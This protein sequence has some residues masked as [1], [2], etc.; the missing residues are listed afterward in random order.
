[1]TNSPLENSYII[2]YNVKNA[3][4]GKS[5]SK[6]PKWPSLRP[7]ECKS[8]FIQQYGKCCWRASSSSQQLFPY[9]SSYSCKNLDSQKSSMF[10][11]DSFGFFHFGIH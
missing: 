11:F 1:M 2:G 10:C 8:K 7:L 3:R 9:K 4:N 5:A 6:I